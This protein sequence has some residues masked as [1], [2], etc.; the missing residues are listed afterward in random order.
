MSFGEKEA[1]MLADFIKHENCNI[2]ELEL[3]EADIEFKALE[4]ILNGIVDSEAFF[5]R[6]SLSKNILDGNICEKLRDFPK[7]LNSFESLCLSHCEIGAAG[8]RLICEGLYGQST[9]K[10]LDL[11]W[12]NVIS[13][14][15]EIILE[16]LKNN[17][18]LEKLLI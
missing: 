7:K 6:L 12:N 9:I 4:I 3:N 15:M 10:Y 17:R 1:I 8:L 16:M 2:E 11:S 14:D 5:K 18:S 13:Q